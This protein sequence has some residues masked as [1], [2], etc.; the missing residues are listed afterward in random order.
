MS[1]LLESLFP[2]SWLKLIGISLVTFYFLWVHFLAVMNLK[3]HEKFIRPV[4]L[5]AAKLVLFNGLLLDLFWQVVPASII[6]LELPKELT[7]SGRVMR[8]CASGHGY[9]YNLAV[10]LKDNW[11]ALFDTSGE[12]GAVSATE[13]KD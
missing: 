13:G 4:P 9:R 5:R 6:F 1:C 3:V 7:V 12:H 11:L 8:L 2:I 10:W